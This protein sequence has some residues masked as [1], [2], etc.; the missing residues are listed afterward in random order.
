MEKA[1]SFYDSP[2]RDVLRLAI[3]GVRYNEKVNKKNRYDIFMEMLA[4]I[5][6]AKKIGMSDYGIVVN[7]FRLADENG[8][9]SKTTKKGMKMKKAIDNLEK[10]LEPDSVL[11]LD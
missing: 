4:K 9:I 11:Y 6:S 10:T 2:F 1:L 7:S 5:A 8:A 3:D